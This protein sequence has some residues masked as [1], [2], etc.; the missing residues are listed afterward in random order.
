MCPL[1]YILLFLSVLVALVGL[2][3]AALEANDEVSSGT[4]DTIMND[5]KKSKFQILIDML[6]G[7]YL[8]NVY[9]GVKN[10]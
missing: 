3:K 10:D 9:R 4:T 8:L 5:K 7:R 1:R 6:S 2:S